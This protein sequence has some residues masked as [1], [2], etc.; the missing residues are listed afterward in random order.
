MF[1]INGNS[2]ETE[3]DK[4]SNLWLLAGCAANN[5]AISFCGKMDIIGFTKR[6]QLLEY[7][8]KGEIDRDKQRIG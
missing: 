5:T 6:C 7:T 1:M 4:S 2:R 8:F 3:L